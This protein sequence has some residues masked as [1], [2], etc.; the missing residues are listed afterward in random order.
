[1]IV[2]YDARKRSWD[3]CWLKTHVVVVVVVIVVVGR[4]LQD[5]PFSLVGVSQGDLF[6]CEIFLLPGVPPSK[7]HSQPIAVQCRTRDWTIPSVWGCMPAVPPVRLLAGGLFAEGASGFHGL[8]RELY[9]RTVLCAD[10]SK[11]PGKDINRR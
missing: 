11:S 3:E 8:S 6:G 9:L 4:E 5:S 1:M 7:L 10:V 2:E